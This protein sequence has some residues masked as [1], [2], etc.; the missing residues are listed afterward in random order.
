MIIIKVGGGETIN[1]DYI[2]QDLIWLLKKE[3]VI[4]I[5]G[6]G[7]IRDKIAKKMGAATKT[8]TSPSGIESVYTDKKAIDIFL[9]VYSGLVNKKIVARLSFYGL[10]PIGLSGVDARLFQA[11]KKKFLLIKEG[12]KIKLLKNTLTGRVE[13]VNY[14]L[15][16][17][18]VDNGYL[19]VICPP[20]I[21]DNGEIVNVDGDWAAVMV[22][23]AFQVKK[24]IFLFEAAGFL[25]NYPDEKSLV[26]RMAKSEIENYL[27]LAFG[28]MKKK[29]FAAK[30]AL[31]MG[32][33]KVYFGDG[34][35]AH[36]IRK[37]YQGKGTIIE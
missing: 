36:P 23:N 32:I 14:Q 16:K 27:P 35:I 24:I 33:K 12:K 11:K 26:K 17:I 10:K 21:T 20:A 2:A 6:A 9:M 15:L 34:R 7:K 30:K 19:P 5:H 28:R 8:I 25:S 3:K 31:E 1:W 22:A 37:I 13:N 4:L 18:L 29:L